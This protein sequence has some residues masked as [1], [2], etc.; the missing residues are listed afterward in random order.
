MDVSQEAPTWAS[1]STW[2]NVRQQVEHQEPQTV[3]KKRQRTDNAAS[4]SKQSPKKH[5]G[6]GEKLLHEAYSSHQVDNYVDADGE[7]DPAVPLS[8]PL[9]NSTADHPPTAS[10]MATPPLEKN[11]GFAARGFKL[12]ALP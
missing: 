6:H 7:P 3:S 2:S 9:N 4:K 12:A 5:R 1:L 10:S 8:T 11:L